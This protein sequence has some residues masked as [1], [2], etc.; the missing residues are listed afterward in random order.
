MDR[1]EPAIVLCTPLHTSSSGNLNGS[2]Q[3]TFDK[4]TDRSGGFGNIEV[5]KAGVD[6]DHKPA[7]VPDTA[8]NQG[9]ASG[10]EAAQAGG[11]PMLRI[12]RMAVMPTATVR[13]HST[14]THTESAIGALLTA[15]KAIGAARTSPSL[16]ARAAP[17]CSARCSGC[18]MQNM[19]RRCRRSQSCTC[20]RSPQNPHKSGSAGR[21]PTQN[22]RT[23]RHSP[24]HGGTAATMALLPL[25]GLYAGSAGLAWLT[26]P[27]VR[28]A[29]GL[30]VS[31]RSAVPICSPAPRRYQQKCSLSCPSLCPCI[32][33]GLSPG[34]T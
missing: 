4:P 22:P 9:A 2:G 25:I 7:G 3:L 14:A 17:S 21:L 5:S 10:R 18:H 28:A 29:T 33:A 27:V 31:G 6:L 15:K 23:K 19:L 20:G 30:L 11:S 16:R 8:R 32:G 26:A 34:M 1:H 13:A 24:A 12:A